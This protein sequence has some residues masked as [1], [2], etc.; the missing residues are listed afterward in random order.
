MNKNLDPRSPLRLDLDGELSLESLT[1]KVTDWCALAE[2]E[3]HSVIVLGLPPPP[4]SRRAWTGDA[5]IQD[6]SRWERAVRRLER[7][8]A[9]IV[10]VGE[11]ARGGAALDLM[12]I[13]DYR[14][15]GVDFRLSPPSEG[16][17]LWP[18]MALHRLTHGLGAAR[19]RQ[20]LLASEVDAVRA[21]A[22]GLADEVAEDVGA[23][24]ARAVVRLAPL[25]GAEF[26]VRRQL[27]LA[28]HT[29]TFDDALGLHL[30]A[31]ER[32]LRYARCIRDEGKVDR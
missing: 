21:Q 12:A 8:S 30:A 29:T 26:A 13:A 1:S 22:I 16:G 10:A 17:R 5:E 6:V 15:V 18:G 23:G 31:C 20:L 28:G 7:S 3:R 19:A 11:G 25:S 24:L 27:V 14:L 4:T 32:E 2:E 9:I